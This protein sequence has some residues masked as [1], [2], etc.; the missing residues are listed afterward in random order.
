MNAS[1]NMFSLEGQVA[2]VTGGNGGLGFAIAEALGNAGA[3]VA[4]V[5]RNE[6]K[7][8]EA[9]ARLRAS[10]I[11]A[12]GHVRE[13]GSKA[14]CQAAAT[15]V[16]DSTGRLDILVNCAGVNIRKRPEDYEEEEILE[17]LSVDLIAPFHLSVA[18]YRLAMRKEGG[19]II[20]IGSLLSTFGGA[21]FAPYAMAKGG[22]VQMTRSMAVA[23]ASDGVRVNAILP[24]W[25]DTDLTKSARQVLPGLNEKVLH[26]TPAGRWGKPEEVGGTAVMLAGR[27]SSFTTGATIC[28]DGGY[29]IAI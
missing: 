13:L 29:G 9:V 21:Q 12:S 8:E 20:N 15:D 16:L 28:I 2:L 25:F 17:I 6:V 19:S 7:T 27:T 24:G 14:A 22:L 23:W 4:I 5:A 26:D 18:A 10:G 3:S 11:A 1:E